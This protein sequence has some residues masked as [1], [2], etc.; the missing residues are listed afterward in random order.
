MHS[1]LRR[2]PSPFVLLLGGAGGAKKIPGGSR[3]LESGCG[4]FC[5]L[6]PGKFAGHFFGG[7][8]AQYDST[9]LIYEQTE[10]QGFNAQS[11]YEGVFPTLQ[12]ADVVRPYQAVGLDSG[13]PFFLCIGLVGGSVQGVGEDLQG[14]AA[15]FG[16]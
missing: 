1:R 15:V 4:M 14:G 16:I 11:A 8:I 6:F 7:R 13:N 5:G 2:V 12:A 3:G 9:F 10:G